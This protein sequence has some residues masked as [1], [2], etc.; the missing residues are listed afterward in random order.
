MGI[1]SYKYI[2]EELAEFR[3][4]NDSFQKDFMNFKDISWIAQVRPFIEEFS[5]EDD[6]VF[7]PFAGMGTTIIAAGTI[8]RK[9]I[10]IEL[11]KERFVNLKKRVDIYKENYKYVPI[12]VNGDALTYEY[13]QDV[14]LVVTNFPYY[15]GT[16]DNSEC[17]NFYNVKSYKKYLEFINDV[18]EKCAA[19]IKKD[20]YM[21]V[22]SENIRDLNGNMIP[23]AYDVCDILRKHMNLKDERILLYEKN[24]QKVDDI[25]VTNRAHEYVF[26]CKKKTS[27]VNCKEYN[28]IL[29]NLGKISEYL[30]IGTYGLFNICKCV[31]DNEPLDCDILIPYDEDNIKKVV[32]LLKDSEYK[33]YSW[34]DEIND[35]FDY[36][37]L[38]GRYYLRAVRE[39]KRENNGNLNEKYIFD[40]TYECEYLNFST[41]FKNKIIK[42]KINIAR[43][44]DIMLLMK[45]RGNYKDKTLL[46]R[47]SQ[48]R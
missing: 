4:N 23:Q 33:V 42:N 9:S 31:L 24:E 30:V 6:L 15:N 40:I 26:I 29:K 35:D 25:T 47:I 22:F 17:G 36:N 20:G 44:E 28:N 38:I 43:L 1:N 13:P 5:K 14:D 34:Q 11:E 46:Y 19:C 32:K 12:L 27:K 3:I 10:G 21:V 2:K 39:V 18:V 7:E 48:L 37:K 45:I 8:G 41:S 16:V